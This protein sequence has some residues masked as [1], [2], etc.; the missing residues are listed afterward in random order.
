MPLSRRTAVA[1][2]VVPLAALLAVACGGGGGGGAGPVVAAADQSL[3]A[4][5][6]RTSYAIRAQLGGQDL[7]LT[8]QGQADLQNRRFRTTLDYSGVLGAVGEI[9]AEAA[10]ALSKPFDLILDG[11]FAY[12]NFPFL[13]QQVGRTEGWVRI[14]LSTS[15]AALAA[16]GG[17]GSI[18][19]PTAF[20]Q[21]L[22]G[23]KTVDT[24]GAER[25]GDT[26]TT[27][28]R[29]ILVIADAL[30]RTSGAEQEAVQRA[31]TNLNVNPEVLGT[32]IPFDVWIGSDGLVRR[33]SFGLDQGP[34]GR[35]DISVDFSGYGAAGDVTLPAPEDTV[36]LAELSPPPADPAN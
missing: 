32:D 19:D 7:N 1:S 3:A 11:N 13:A 5:S 33:L 34:A 4:T 36:D 16:L 14:D 6:V 35:T 20:V 27:H 15:S 18:L 21:F 17:G 23:A 12:V 25:I 9:P 22:R 30:E 31:V 26:D 2:I 28:Y 8:G 24:V 29:G 10:E